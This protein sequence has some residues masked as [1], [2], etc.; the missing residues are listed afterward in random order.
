VIRASP[1]VAV[2][3]PIRIRKIELPSPFDQERVDLTGAD[4]K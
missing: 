1:R 2:K 3:N 4:L